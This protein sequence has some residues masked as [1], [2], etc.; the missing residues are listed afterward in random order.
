[1]HHTK[2]RDS[3]CGIGGQQP[4]VIAPTQHLCDIIYEASGN[5]QYSCEWKSAKPPTPGNPGGDTA[6]CVLSTNKCIIPPSQPTPQPSIYKNCYYP[7]VNIADNSC[8]ILQKSDP[9]VKLPNTNYII[10]DFSSLSFKYSEKIAEGEKKSNKVWVNNTLYY[11]NPTVRY[12]AGGKGTN[13]VMYPWPL[14]NMNNPYMGNSLGGDISGNNSCQSNFI[15][16]FNH[17][18]ANSKYS[19]GLIGLDT[20]QMGPDGC[21]WGGGS[22]WWQPLVDISTDNKSLI[23]KPKGGNAQVLPF[24]YYYYGKF[25]AGVVM[26]QDNWNG[27]LE[28]KKQGLISGSPYPSWPYWN[29]SGIKFCGV[30]VKDWTD[31][32]RGSPELPPYKLGYSIPGLTN[33]DK[34]NILS[35]PP[36]K[37][38]VDLFNSAITDMNNLVTEAVTFAVYVTNLA[39]NSFSVNDISI[40]HNHDLYENFKD[41]IKLINN[42]P[43]LSASDILNSYPTSNCGNSYFS[44]FSSQILSDTN[45]KPIGIPPSAHSVRSFYKYYNPPLTTASDEIY[46][47]YNDSKHTKYQETYRTSLRNSITYCPNSLAHTELG[48][49]AKIPI[50]DVA[51]AWIWTVGSGEDYNSSDMSSNLYDRFIDTPAALIIIAGETDYDTSGAICPGLPGDASAGD[52]KLHKVSYTTSNTDLNNYITNNIKILVPSNGGIWQVTSPDTLPNSCSMNEGEENIC[53]NDTVAT[54]VCCTADYVNSHLFTTQNGLATMGTFNSSLG[55]CSKSNVCPGVA[56]GGKGLLYSEIANQ[57]LDQFMH[58]SPGPTLPP[59]PLPPS[60]VCNKGPGTSYDISGCASYNGQSWI[61][62]QCLSSNQYCLSSPKSSSMT[63]IEPST[64]IYYF[65]ENSLRQVQAVDGQGLPNPAVY[66]YYCGGHQGLCHFTQNG[67]RVPTPAPS[68]PPPPAPKPTPP[69]PISCACCT[70]SQNT[71]GKGPDSSAC[72]CVLKNEH[73]TGNVCWSLGE[74]DTTSLDYGTCQN[75]GAMSKEPPALFVECSASMLNCPTPPPI[76]CPTSPESCSN[77]YCI[78]NTLKGKSYCY[79]PG[80]GKAY[81]PPLTSGICSVEYPT[82]PCKCIGTD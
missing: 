30:D 10:P 8:S 52:G 42:L 7:N 43:D 36:K 16:P 24:P 79:N 21:N 37:T 34:I 39:K 68:P 20:M 70:F 13:P 59:S 5:D 33:P 82:T 41:K 64:S 49:K 57:S 28:M 50:I 26:G 67:P 35:N 25:Y 44:Q 19:Q 15:G 76:S 46:I 58:C 1:M 23:I 18:A 56:S 6:K 14:N 78:N 2:I 27:S 66:A 62:V 72:Y 12:T 22:Q 29:V 71:C 9:W 53:N 17:G 65:D 74:K 11:S 48:S 54:N 3:K 32:E 4:C 47:N 69:T 45:I 63:G 40:E 75:N 38:Q 31:T 73:N 51:K 77:K 81:C 61:V 55:V 80:D 60:P